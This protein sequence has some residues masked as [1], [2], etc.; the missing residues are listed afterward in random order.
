M[1]TN[2]TTTIY[3]TN[4]ENKL[5]LSINTYFN[6]RLVR[7]NPTDIENILDNQVIKNFF[8]YGIK[9]IKQ[10]K[11]IFISDNEKKDYL[12]IKNTINNNL[13]VISSD[14][15]KYFSD[16]EQYLEL[17]KF[18]LSEK[19]LIDIIT[20]NKVDEII[21]RTS[22]K[23]E[24][25]EIFLTTENEKKVLKYNIPYEYNENG[26]KIFKKEQLDVIQNLINNYFYINASELSYT[27]E[28]G[29]GSFLEEF[30]IYGTNDSKVTI[31]SNELY[32]T[33]DLYFELI[34]RY[35]ENEKIENA[36]Q[37][38]KPFSRLRLLKNDKK[39]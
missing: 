32:R 6:N 21:I 19:A 11:K 23:E 15:S 16:L 13:L 5:L 34:K 37:N 22:D 7:S 20:K 28:L 17:N 2:K 3:L 27:S 38:I 26:K 1:G 35:I 31:C 18:S 14:F 24:V 33:L 9:E 10:L 36:K 25:S 29:F 30:S 8:K 39:N 4:N 12:E